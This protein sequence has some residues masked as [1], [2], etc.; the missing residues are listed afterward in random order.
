MAPS[1]LRQFI[2]GEL[3]LFTNLVNIT[4]SYCCLC[5][6]RWPCIL[7]GTS[8][9]CSLIKQFW[10]SITTNKLFEFSSI[11]ITIY[12]KLNTVDHSLQFI[13]DFRFIEFFYALL[14]W[15]IAD[16]GGVDCIFH[17]IT[18]PIHYAAITC[19]IV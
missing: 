16:I 11:L 10:T 13:L 5:A 12:K 3:G 9:E 14:R 6:E 18:I 1:H 19:R 7:A 4:K 8:L 2:N 17:H 15:V